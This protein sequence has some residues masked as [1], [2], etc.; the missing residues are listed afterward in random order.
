[1]S[2]GVFESRRSAEAA[3]VAGRGAPILVRPGLSNRA[4]RALVRVS[5]QGMPNSLMR[6][7]VAKGGGVDEW[8]STVG[9]KKWTRRVA[10][11]AAAATVTYE[12]RYEI[13]GASTMDYEYE[14]DWKT[15]EGWDAV[16][17]A[18]P[19]ERAAPVLPVAASAAGWDLRTLFGQIQKDG[20]AGV[21]NALTAAYLA[22]MVAPQ[23]GAHGIS[24][25]NYLQVVALK[26][27]LDQVAMRTREDS[28]DVTAEFLQWASARGLGA[29]WLAGLTAGMAEAAYRDFLGFAQRADP[30]RGRVSATAEG[31]YED[32]T[33]EYLYST[34]DDL[35]EPF[36]DMNTAFQGIVVIKAD[37]LEE[38]TDAAAADDGIAGHEFAIRYDPNGHRFSIYDQ[39]GGLVRQGI[40]EQEQIAEILADYLY[41]NYID[42]PMMP[43]GPDAP[44]VNNG[45]FTIQFWP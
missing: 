37:T 45:S 23:E 1:M 8:D 7:W 2:R 14:G 17:I 19:A 28:G 6:A 4:M 39:T 11:S 29:A 18:I 5:P 20:L 40:Q 42:N 30:A 43:A 9:S 44:P 3:P 27:L 33:A 35:L 38:D 12:Y 41:T 36:F 21:C 26:G 16:S 10:G 31:R 34:I 32:L 22:D 13:Q 24:E 25:Q 15:K